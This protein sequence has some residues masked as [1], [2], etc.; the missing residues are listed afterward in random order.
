M[1]RKNL[2]I[3]AAVGLALLFAGGMLAL[4]TMKPA[5]P[6]GPMVDRTVLERGHS[7]TLGPADAPVTIVEFIDPACETCADFYPFVKSLMAANEGKVRLIMR[8]APFH[9]GSQDVVAMLEA[10]RK[11]DKLWPALEALLQSQA[12]WSPNHTP[13]VA[14][15]MEQLK[16][17]GLNRE[18][19]LADMAS[20]DVLGRI[21]QDIADVQALGVKATP[22]FF[23]NGKPMPSFGYEQ[24]RG[25]VDEAVAATGKGR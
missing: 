22:E 8:W 1:N 21:N 16:P 4:R 24:L 5:E 9:N 3:G 13:Q 17:L 6:T 15:A 19:L 2:F 23:V 14:A 25:L 18:Q 10:A 20:A 12:V 7:A 11:Q